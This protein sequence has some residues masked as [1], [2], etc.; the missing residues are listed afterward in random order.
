M[1]KN[2]VHLTSVSISAI[3][4]TNSHVTERERHQSLANCLAQPPKPAEA[5]RG[6]PVN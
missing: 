1:G 6:P 2:D 5:R 3:S 4:I